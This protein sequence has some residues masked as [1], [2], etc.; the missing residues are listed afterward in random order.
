M[1]REREKN[2][3]KN[4][5]RRSRGSTVYLWFNS[6]VH[7][8]SS[9]ATK[10]YMNHSTSKQFPLLR[11]QHRERSNPGVNNLKRGPIW[12]HVTCKAREINTEKI[13][14]MT[15]C[16]DENKCLALTCHKYVLWMSAD[17]QKQQRQQPEMR[18][19]QYFLLICFLLSR[20]FLREDWAT[21]SEIERG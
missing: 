18:A 1:T 11:W 7:I 12:F 16:G 5:N 14:L 10:E 9:L 21:G 6:P 20:S 2:K 13:C 19:L 4:K 8:A 17:D 3:N 15:M